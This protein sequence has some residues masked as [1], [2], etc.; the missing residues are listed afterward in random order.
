MLGERT[1]LLLEVVRLVRVACDHEIRAPIHGH[2]CGE[3]LA[4][5]AIDVVNIRPV[6]VLDRER[7]VDHRQGGTCGARFRDESMIVVLTRQI[8][9]RRLVAVLAEDDL[10]RVVELSRDDEQVGHVVLELVGRQDFFAKVLF[11]PRC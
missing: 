5:L 1:D 11:N 2:V 7:R 6:H 3:R 9:R 10:A 4:H 8:V